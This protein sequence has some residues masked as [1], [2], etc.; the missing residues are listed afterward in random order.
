MSRGDDDPAR[1][2]ARTRAAER[3]AERSKLRTLAFDCVFSDVTTAGWAKGTACFWCEAEGVLLINAWLESD[4]AR[5]IQVSQVF[6][7][8]AAVRKAVEFTD[9]WFKGDLPLVERGDLP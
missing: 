6:S 9:L 5:W 4:P 2:R 3:A 7:R 1:A 8:A